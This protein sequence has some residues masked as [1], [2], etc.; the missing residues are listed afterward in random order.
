MTIQSGR[1]KRQSKPSAMQSSSEMRRRIS[2]ALLAD[3]SCA[4]GGPKHT[5]THTHTA[6][7]QPLL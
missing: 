2:S 5:H 6:G 7:R 1:V 4:R 3:T